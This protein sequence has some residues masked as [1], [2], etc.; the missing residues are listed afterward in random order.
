[1]RSDL[2]VFS[3]GQQRFALPVHQVATVV[4]RASLTPLPGAPR[5]LIGMLRLRGALF[6]VIDIRA[7]LGLPAAAPRI[8][9]CIVL[10]QTTER[11]VGLIV[12][13]VEGLMTVPVDQL[14]ARAAAQHGGLVREIWEA[15]S[16]VVAT[17]DADV[18]V[19]I[20]VGDYLASIASGPAR[21]LESRAA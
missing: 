17:L 9:D 11:T 18:V 8:G 21:L 14:D 12:E 7:R 5:D 3:L 16:Q 20:E 1:M 2:L 15:S 19:G 13:S 10:M 4:P 6:P